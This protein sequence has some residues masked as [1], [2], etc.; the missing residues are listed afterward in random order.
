MKVSVSG[1]A[2]SA[3]GP[4]GFDR[5]NDIHVHKTSAMRHRKIFMQKHPQ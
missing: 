5:L 3:V 2:S 1:G 4:P